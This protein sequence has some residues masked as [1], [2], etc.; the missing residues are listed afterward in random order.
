[1]LQRLLKAVAATASGT[2]TT[3]AAPKASTAAVSAAPTAAATTTAP[4]TIFFRTRLIYRQVTAAHAH[5]VQGFHGF[6]CRIVVRHLNEGK[7]SRLS[8]VTVGHDTH[9]V[10]L[11]V[12]LEQRAHLF[13][14]GIE[15]Q[16]AYVDIFHFIL[17]SES[18]V[19]AGKTVANLRQGC[20]LRRKPQDANGPRIVTKKPLHGK[21]HAHR[22]R[23]VS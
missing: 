15:L 5:S 1:M 23:R 2:A 8:G 20:C 3:T 13:F 21:C 12:R 22:S 4:G 16:I 17:A 7:S 9:P 10:Y 6:G 14:I 18:A 11:S 19:L